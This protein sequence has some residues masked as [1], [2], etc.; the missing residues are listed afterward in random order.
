MKNIFAL[1]LTATLILSAL[2]LVGCGSNNTAD[3]SSSEATVEVDALEALKNVWDNYEEENKFAVIGGDMSNPVSDGPGEFGLADAAEVN[4]KIG[5]P[6]DKV[7]TIDKAATLIHMMNA[8]T[9][10]AAAVHAAEGNNVEDIATTIGDN[11]KTRQWM[12]GIPEKHVILKVGSNTII[13][14]FGANEIVTVFLDK[15]KVAYPDNTI[16]LE[17]TFE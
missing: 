1:I 13:S 7:A 6:E 8:N 15:V 5:I 4:D 17:Q 16:L 11:L 2:S 14:A 9:F 10:S 3:N 12:C